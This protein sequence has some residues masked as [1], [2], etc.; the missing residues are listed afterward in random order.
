MPEAQK[1]HKIRIQKILVGTDFSA[2]S[3]RALAYAAMLSEQ[4]GS[5]ILL[6]HVIESLSYSMTDSLT[7]IGHEKALSATAEVLLENL[8]KKLVDQGRPAES[9][10]ARG[11]PYQEIMRQAEE[12]GC[13]LIVL[14]THGR[15]GIEHFLLGSVAE[16]VVRLSHCPVLTVPAK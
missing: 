11:T 10:L 12:E 3:D 1:D 6:L 9:R 8:L 4:F 5:A 7:V 16:R 14:G 13:D 15:T 2:C